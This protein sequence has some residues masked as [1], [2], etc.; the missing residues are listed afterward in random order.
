MEL[1]LSGPHA[2]A[3][4]GQ[5]GPGP[6]LRGAGGVGGERSGARGRGARCMEAW[7]LAVLLAAL[8]VA[9]LHQLIAAREQLQRQRGLVAAR[10]AAAA[11]PPPPPRQEA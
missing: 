10:N 6:L 1:E 2:N 3:G 9:V 8:G 4:E 11:L 7:G 5:A